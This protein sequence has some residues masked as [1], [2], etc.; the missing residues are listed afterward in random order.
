[1]IIKIQHSH[2]DINNFTEHTKAF[3]KDKHMESK[4][5]GDAF[6]CT[7]QNRW[8]NFSLPESRSF[9]HASALKKK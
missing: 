1:M 9:P 6:L 5:K 4:I 2:N 7:Q 8:F 3:L